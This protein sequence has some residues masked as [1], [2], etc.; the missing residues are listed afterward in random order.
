MSDIAAF[1]PEIPRDEVERMFRKLRDTRLP[2]EPIVP[3]AGDD[4]GT[5][6]M[7]TCFVVEKH[8]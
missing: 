4:Y 6:C 7:D 2:S 3:D 1:D 8:E 5:Y